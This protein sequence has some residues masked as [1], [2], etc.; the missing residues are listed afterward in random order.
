MMRV[1]RSFLYVIFLLYANTGFSA[2]FHVPTEYSTIQAGLVAAY[3]G[4][5]VL[6]ADGIYTGEGNRDI[7]FMGRAIHLMS[8][9]GPETCIID[10]QGTEEDRNRGFW[11]RNSEDPDSILDGFTIRNGYAYD[12]G[13]IRIDI[14]CSPT[15][16]GCIITGNTAIRDGG[17]ICCYMADPVITGNL[18]SCNRALGAGGGIYCEDSQPLIGG[19]SPEANRFEYNHAGAGSD[20]YADAYDDFIDASYNTFQGM[21]YS[22]YYVKP[23]EMFILFG[24][25]SETAP[26]DQ[27]VYVS[28]TGNDQNDGLTWDTAFQTV[29][30]AMGRI[31]ATPSHP[32]TIHLGTGVYSETITGELYPVAMVPY[33]TLSGAGAE[34]TVLDGENLYRQMFGRQSDDFLLSG[35]TLTGGLARYGGAVFFEETRCCI[36]DCVITANHAT[37]DGGGIYG[38]ND[39]FLTLTNCRVEGN[40]ADRF[41][42]GVS[43]GPYTS[44]DIAYCEINDNTAVRQ[45]G[46]IFDWFG[47]L[48][49]IGCRIS[50]NTTTLSEGGMTIGFQST[51]KL[52]D[53]IISDNTTEGSSGGMSLSD[54]FCTL[55]NCAIL[56]NYAAEKGG[57]I[58][59]GN[60]HVVLN[61][62]TLA[63]NTAGTMGGG[64]S[65]RT[66]NVTTFVN[67]IIWANI[68]P[69]GY[70]LNLEYGSRVNL[71]YSLISDDPDAILLGDYC[72][73][74]WGEG[75]ISQDPLFV[76]GPMGEFYL[77][78][79]AAEQLETSPCVDAGSNQAEEIWFSTLDGFKF[80][81]E[82]TTRSDGIMDLGIV[83][84]GFHYPAGTPVGLME[85]KKP[86][87][88]S[89]LYENSNPLPWHGY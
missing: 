58:D 48:T 83:D 5:T 41:A 36:Q 66:E 89:E 26:I 24:C 80:L 74:N 50:G 56:N 65:S 85:W 51:A 35:V 7:N 25:I 53:C 3:S 84:M 4:D 62:C 16:T 8:E 44:A 10:C 22:D 52:A 30:H 71:G 88:L 67:S 32:R 47:T 19:S 76:T 57:G 13:G 70:D 60:A 81:D 45:G 28:V 34:N 33:V 63:G 2:V 64:I 72:R 27:D 55:T 43:L 31:L 37:E 73:L 38:E 87:A 75:T 77:S 29:K 78:H 15:I 49:M 54:T 86:F 46:L 1:S 6:V 12:G 14:N 18:F 11:F 9:N 40:T 61:N 82:F 23:T 20:L 39:S 68:A 79:Q 59:V 69:E 17:G 42:G 21:H